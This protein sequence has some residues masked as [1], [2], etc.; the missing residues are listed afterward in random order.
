MPTQR[1]WIVTTL[2]AFSAASTLPGF[3]QEAN[4]Q[5]EPP[6]TGWRRFGEP[7]Q[8]PPPAEA[9]QAPSPSSAIT[10]PAGTWITVRVNEPLSSDH[11]QQGDAFTATLA[12]PLV[13]NG[14]V[15]AR[16]GQT[17]AGVVAEALKAGHVKGTSR[18]GLQ[19]TEI[20]LADGRQIQINSRVIERRGNTSV[21]Q[22]AAVIG[23]T[24]GIGAAIGA[25]A[26]GGFGA[27]MGAIAGAA[28][29]TIGVLATRGRATEV[30][31]ETPL[32][33]RLDTP[34]NI[35]AEYAE[36]FPPVTQQDY[37][38][39]SL[40]RQGPSLRQGPPPAPYYY[41]GVYSPYYYGYPYAYGPSLFFYS[42][43][44]FYYGRG[45]YRRW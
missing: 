13:A 3:A 34:I 16:R 23:T 31:P 29:S 6:S 1:K 37:E 22:D 20:G 38:Q 14:R 19:L 21:G 41:S 43:P 32:T 30:Y 28:A 4:Q 9:D 27:G 35:P 45:H 5:N 24:T 25:A 10:V 8:S 7:A 2:L 17:V 33:F 11:N 36:A 40:A 42:G 18:L 15:I 44:R 39:R 12:Q 26:D